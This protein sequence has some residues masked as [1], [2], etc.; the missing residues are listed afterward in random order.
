L[1]QEALAAAESIKPLERRVHDARKRGEITAE[2]TPGQIAQAEDGGIL[3]HSEARELERFDALVM[4]LTGVDDFDP[5]EL[6]R[7][8]ADNAVRTPAKKK[9]AKKKRV[10]RKKRASKAQSRNSEQ[11][12]PVSESSDSQSDVSVSDISESRPPEEQSPEEQ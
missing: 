10:T 3:T 5:S 9:P 7:I 4:E 11:M 8:T 6:P 2:D 1:L 12:T